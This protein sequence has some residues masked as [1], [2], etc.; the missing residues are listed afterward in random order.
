MEQTGNEFHAGSD[1]YFWNKNDLVQRLVNYCWNESAHIPM[2]LNKKANISVPLVH[3]NCLGLD[4]CLYDI[5]EVAKYTGKTG[6]DALSKAKV[7]AGLQVEYLPVDGNWW[8][9]YDPDIKLLLGKLQVDN[10]YL[11]ISVIASS[12]AEK[13][14]WFQEQI[15]ILKEKWESDSVTRKI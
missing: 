5:E 4:I 1:T 14:R 8:H 12:E 6:N 10:A 9:N 7:L 3:T 11:M 13:V 2:I 15:D